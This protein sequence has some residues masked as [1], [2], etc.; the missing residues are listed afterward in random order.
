L[1]S[2]KQLFSTK[3]QE[4]NGE[5]QKFSTKTT[6]MENIFQNKMSKKEQELDELRQEIDKRL[7]KTPVEKIVEVVVEK[8]STDNSLKP[9][10]DA[11]QTT[12][13]KV[14]QETLEKDKKIRELEQTIQEIQKL[15]EN[16]QAIYFNGSN[17]NNK[18]NN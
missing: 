17:L 1:E 10:L 5:V 12:L 2:D 14:R 11:L 4:C 7:D 15:Q 6:E 9:K 16:K 8:E 3:L 13:A 18:L